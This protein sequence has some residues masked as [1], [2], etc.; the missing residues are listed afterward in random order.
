MFP[1][2]A[3]LCGRD[4]DTSGQ[5]HGRSGF[6]AQLTEGEGSGQAV[7]TNEGRE[8]ITMAEENRSHGIEKGLV[9]GREEGRE[10]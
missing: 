1:G 10:Q 6:S 4:G 3:F 7:L 8:R 9:P 5:V 2:E